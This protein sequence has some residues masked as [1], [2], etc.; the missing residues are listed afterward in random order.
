MRC[1][2]PTFLYKSNH[3][4]TTKYK[5]SIIFS[6]YPFWFSNAFFKKIIIFLDDEDD[7]ID[8]AKVGTKTGQNTT[9]TTTNKQNTVLEAAAAAV[10]EVAAEDEDGSEPESEWEYFYEDAELKKPDGT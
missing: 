7:E 2:W 8:A 6:I 3:D 5:D 10:A 4:L 9:T 1:C